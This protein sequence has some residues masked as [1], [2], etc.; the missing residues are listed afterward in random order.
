MNDLE[1]LFV[2]ELKDIYDGEQQLLK[3]LRQMEEVA[4]SEE[5]KTAFRNHRS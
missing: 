3:A 5:L 4:V 1:K 2:S